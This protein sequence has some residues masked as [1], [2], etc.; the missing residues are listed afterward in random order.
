M[1]IGKKSEE[2]EEEKEEE[3]SGKENLCSICLEIVSSA[4]DRST[5]RLKC[6]HEFHLDC[7]GSAFNVKG[8]MQCPNCR[9]VEKGNWLYA[10]R[11]SRNVPVPD[12]NAMD[13][14]THDEDLYDLTYSEIPFGVH[15]CPFGRIAQLPT[16]FEDGEPSAPVTFSELFGPQTMF[17]DHVN[18]PT[19]TGHPCPY[20]TYI[21]PIHANPP[22]SSS[23]SSSTSPSN[24]HHHHPSGRTVVGQPLPVLTQHPHQV[25]VD[26]RYN[27]WDSHFSRNAYGGNVMQVPSATS[28]PQQDGQSRGVNTMF[29]F[30][31][32]SSSRAGNPTS[33]IPPLV[34]Q[35]IRSD[36]SIPEHYIPP[37]SSAT[38]G[39][40][41]HVANTM[42]GSTAVPTSTPIPPSDSTNSF[43]MFPS[44]S[45]N[46]TSV[47]TE[48]AGGN[49]FY[50][51]E[52]DRFAP[53]PL[54]P[55]ENRETGWWSQG[56]APRPD[57]EQRR[58]F[59]QPLRGRS[60]SS[61]HRPSHVPR[62]QSFM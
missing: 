48:D 59:W 45:S 8:V 49:R 38:P 40:L 18:I 34:P 14:W 35:F 15:W 23:L 31:G 17:A 4:G 5:A 10:S 13:E 2:K 55:V 43:C 21:N 27:I 22:P 9:K 41:T 33:L 52:R 25:P 20:L 7:I 26:F 53:F 32:S 51:W 16:F 47:P 36:P 39:L 58:G 28:V 1:G 60:E 44:T 42:G 56:Q 54:A 37:P 19:A 24:G 3:S 61:S 57:S 62:M 29:D 11:P 12:L 46:S 50:A 6:G 30:L